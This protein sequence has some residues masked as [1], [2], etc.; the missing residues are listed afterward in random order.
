MWESVQT[1][2]GRD[3]GGDRSRFAVNQPHSREFRVK[4][5]E[6]NSGAGGP[7]VWAT[8]PGDA[9]GACGDAVKQVGQLVVR[10]RSGR[11]S[12]G[13]VGWPAGGP[14]GAIGGL[15]FPC[16]ALGLAA[17]PNAELGTS[18]GWKSGRAAG[19]ESASVITAR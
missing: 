2:S 7:G 9:G 8:P 5:G 19:M 12:G 10:S 17:V 16:G 1:G 13:G 6:A 15:P 3:R 18:L 14:T 11:A 4:A